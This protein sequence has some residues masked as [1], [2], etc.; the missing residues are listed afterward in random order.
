MARHARSLPAAAMVAALTL[1]GPPAAAQ[2]PLP[3]QA[4]PA[5]SS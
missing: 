2:N 1:T 4:D 5:S 3:E